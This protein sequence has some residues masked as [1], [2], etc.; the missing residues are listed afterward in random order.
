MLRGLKWEDKPLKL[1]RSIKVEEIRFSWAQ[2]ECHYGFRHRR[3]VGSLLNIFWCCCCFLF[4]NFQKQ[5]AFDYSF[6][7]HLQVHVNLYCHYLETC[8]DGIVRVT[9]LISTGRLSVLL[10]FSMAH[11][12]KEALTFFI[13]I[14]VMETW[15]CM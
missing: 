6:A 3:V 8:F 14:S 4:S 10:C 9:G 1:K 11:E 2:I 13:D 7:N 5:C 15:E 12:I